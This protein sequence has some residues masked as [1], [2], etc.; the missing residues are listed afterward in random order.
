MACGS[1]IWEPYVCFVTRWIRNVNLWQL[2]VCRDKNFEFGD[3]RLILIY[4]DS[5]VVFIDTL[6]L[7]SFL[8]LDG[9]AR[10][11]SLAWYTCFLDVVVVVISSLGCWRIIVLET[12]QRFMVLWFTLRCIF[13]FPWKLC[14]CFVRFTSK[15]AFRT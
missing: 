2:K 7:I 14:V 1:C 8:F 12:I 15:S 9:V 11:F 10:D 13:A 5:G 4:P 3:D 6:F